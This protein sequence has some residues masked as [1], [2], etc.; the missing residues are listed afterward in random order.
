M[1]TSVDRPEVV[2]EI[3]I[4]MDVCQ[5]D[6]LN[7]SSEM[8]LSSLSGVQIPGVSTKSRFDTRFLHGAT[9]STHKNFVSHTENP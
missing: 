2:Y 6:D 7:W 9:I 3:S 8:H 1:Y 4:V 5:R